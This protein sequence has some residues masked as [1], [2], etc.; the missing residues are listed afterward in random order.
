[1]SRNEN[2][3]FEVELDTHAWVVNK[4]GGTS[5]ASAEAMSRVT[6]IVMGQV[7]RWV[8][9]VKFPTDFFFSHSECLHT[10]RHRNNTPADLLSSIGCKLRATVYNPGGPHPFQIILREY[11]APCGA[12]ATTP[13]GNF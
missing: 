10:S 9:A 2:G 5:V 13:R 4:F 1:M 11:A 3:G 8:A 7:R 6:E 12:T